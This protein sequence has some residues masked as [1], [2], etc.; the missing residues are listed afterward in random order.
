MAPF[1]RPV[2]PYRTPTSLYG[3]VPVRPGRP[4]RGLPTTQYRRPMF[5]QVFPTIVDYEDIYD[6]WSQM[7]VA[8][9]EC[10]ARSVAT[11]PVASQHPPLA[12]PILRRPQSDTTLCLRPENVV[13]SMNQGLENCMSRNSM[14]SSQGR[15]RHEFRS[16]PYLD[17][18]ALKQCQRGAAAEGYSR[19]L[20][21]Y[22]WRQKVQESMR[23]MALVADKGRRNAERQCVQEI[24]KAM[25]EKKGEKKIGE[26]KEEEQIVEGEAQ[27][28]RRRSCRKMVAEKAKATLR[29]VSSKLGFGT[30]R[31]HGGRG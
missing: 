25:N 13:H 6:R 7:A 29:C 21:V 26:K 18:Q 16:A 11:M 20:G 4:T 1:P 28:G 22:E 23:D 2:P 3:P 10:I 8:Y 17:E 30:M 24:E 31:C 9:S 12:A 19:L 14:P 5:V 15:G 27:D